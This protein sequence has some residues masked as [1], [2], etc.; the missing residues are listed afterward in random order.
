V[1]SSVAGDRG[2]QSNYV[3][4]T[5]KGAVS[6]F[7]QG[8]RNR[9]ARAGVKVVTIK[10]GAVDTPMTAALKKG[11]V[12]DACIGRQADPSRDGERRGH[13]LHAVVLALDHGD[14]QGRARIDFQKDPSLKVN[15]T[16]PVIAW[17]AIFGCAPTPF[18]PAIEQTFRDPIYSKVVLEFERPALKVTMSR[19]V[20]V[21]GAGPSAWPSHGTRPR[22]GTRSSC[23]KP[24][25]CPEAWPRT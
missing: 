25:A 15:L 23:S 9:L 7:A 17:P 11:A 14:H 2:R 16:F 24:T 18:R 22:R 12:V 8:L 20:V 19:V 4:E 3:Y 13:R 10:P 5:A 1:I 21:I 6:I